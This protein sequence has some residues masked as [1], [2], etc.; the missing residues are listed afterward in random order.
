MSETKMRV[1]VLVE[2]TAARADLGAEHGLAYWIEVGDRRVLFD[3]GQTDLI[4]RN[5]AALEVD[6][7]SADTIVLSH[8]HFDHTGGLAAVLPLCPE[9]RVFIHP[10]AFEAKF[11]RHPDGKVHDISMPAASAEALHRHAG[12]VTQTD[13]PAEIVDRLFATGAV[14]RVNDFE[15]TG[16]DF[17]LDAACTTPDPIVDDQALYFRG[18]EGVA[19]LLGCA[20]AGVVNT[21]EHIAHLTEGKP[22]HTVLGGMHLHSAIDRRLAATTE[23]LRAHSIAL[24]GPAHCT[25]ADPTALLRARFP[26]AFAECHA[27]SR[28]DFS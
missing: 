19:V 15:D 12:P 26:D 23:A 25:G 2:N 11:S 5:A 10:R 8:G 14:P 9:A 1:T 27:G 20:H 6:L 28:F 21:L 16:G 3:T 17:H 18:S 4:L 24:L 22:I 13:Q 7:A